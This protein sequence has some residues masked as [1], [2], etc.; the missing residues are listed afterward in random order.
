VE[1]TSLR[2]F[3]ALCALENKR[4]YGADVSNAFAEAPPPAQ[5]FY[6]RVDHVFQ[7]WW[8]TPLDAPNLSDTLT[9]PLQRILFYRHLDTLMGRHRPNYVG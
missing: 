1:Q 6:M 4:I 9:K 7:H 2:L 5:T 3:F 8:T